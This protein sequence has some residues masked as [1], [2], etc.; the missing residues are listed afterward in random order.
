VRE[1]EEFPLHVRL[2][3]SSLY[4]QDSEGGEGLC[5]DTDSKVPKGIDAK[6]QDNRLVAPLLPLQALNWIAASYMML[7]FNAADV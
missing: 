4:L 5:S 6:L 2:Y 7:R 1:P 3:S